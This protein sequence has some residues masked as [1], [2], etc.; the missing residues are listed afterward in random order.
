MKSLNHTETKFAFLT[1]PVGLTTMAG[2]KPLAR[3][4]RI[5]DLVLTELIRLGHHTRI[6]DRVGRSCDIFPG[7]QIV[8][9]FGNRYA[10]DQFEGYVPQEPVSECHLMSIGG[11]CGQVVSQQI[12]MDPPT[13]L[14]VH[15]AVCG[16]DEQP[17][18]LRAF[19]LPSRRWISIEERR[20]ELVLIVGSSMNS[21]K[22][23]TMGTLARALRQEG[24]R[25]AAAKSPGPPRAKMGGTSRVAARGRCWISRSR[26]IRPPICLN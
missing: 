14:R 22:T 25:V 6:E 1:H 16:P 20:S 17:L 8:A 4:P 13:T 21:G 7:D 10:T 11:V 3:A 26:D 18:N 15:G 24:F 2:V 12:S 19:G 23:T 9:A 5:G